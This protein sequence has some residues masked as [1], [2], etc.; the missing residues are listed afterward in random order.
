[1]I[2]VVDASAIGA[3]LFE[4]PEGATVRAHVREE[5]LIAPY[6]LDYE[7]ANIALKKVRRGVEPAPL[8]WVMLTRLETIPIRRVSVPPVDVA[9]LARRTG[10]SAYDASYLWLAMS[11]D[12]ELVTL[13]AKLARVDRT[14]RGDPS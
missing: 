12:L 8:V 10:L 2:L 3:V 6:L 14:L 4:E 5:T 7:L 13:D 9:E 11:H 1:M